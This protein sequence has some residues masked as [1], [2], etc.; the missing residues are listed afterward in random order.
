MS[1]FHPKIS[2]FSGLPPP[3]LQPEVN[4][5]IVLQGDETRKALVLLLEANTLQNIQM[6]SSYAIPWTWEHLEVEI[7][8]MEH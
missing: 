6:Q 1:F 8:S 7:N 4:I 5:T 2:G 3:L